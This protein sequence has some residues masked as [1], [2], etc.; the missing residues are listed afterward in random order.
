MQKPNQRKRK[1]KK[2][3][4]L[5]NASPFITRGAEDF[6]LFYNLRIYI[7]VIPHVEYLYECA[8]K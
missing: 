5:K 1:G 2:I 6:V 7:Y 8:R 4:K 3:F